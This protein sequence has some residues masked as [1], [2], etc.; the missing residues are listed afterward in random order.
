MSDRSRY[1]YLMR[2][3]EFLC[4]KCVEEPEVHYCAQITGWGF[5]AK[6]EEFDPQW[7]VMMA[8]EVE[9]DTR[10]AHCYLDSW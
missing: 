1:G 3:G 5:L 2:D 8:H 9:K 7:C 10:C 6:C 4:P